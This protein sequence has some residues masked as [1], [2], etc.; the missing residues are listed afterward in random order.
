MALIESTEYILPEG[1]CSIAK[2]KFHKYPKWIKT[3]VTSLLILGPSATA[4]RVFSEYC[5]WP[6]RIDR[7]HS[8]C[9]IL[10]SIADKVPV[11]KSISIEVLALEKDS[12]KAVPSTNTCIACAT[13]YDN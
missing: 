4:K 6:N 11:P 1:Y 10:L 13:Q 7:V 8:F 3:E 5:K 9:R 12:K 2:I